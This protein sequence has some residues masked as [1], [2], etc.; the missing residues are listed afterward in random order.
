MSIKRTNRIN[1]IAYIIY[2]IILFNGIIFA[3]NIKEIDKRAQEYYDN[4]EFGKAIAEWLTML[5]IDPENEDVQR[6]IE[7]VYDEKH[8]KDISLQKATLYYKLAHKTMKSNIKVIK[9]ELFLC[10]RIL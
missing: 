5:E 8:K 6:K 9:K 10:H 1:R 4:K 2:I 7:M 3:Q